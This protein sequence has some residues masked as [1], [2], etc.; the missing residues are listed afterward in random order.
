[1]IRSPA[2]FSLFS[3][4]VFWAGDTTLIAHDGEDDHSHNKPSKVKQAQRY[5]PSVIPDRMILTI[6]GDPRTTQSVTW[7]TSI[8][9]ARGLVEIA[10]ADGSPSF[11]KKAE[12]FV[13]STELLESNLSKANYHS[14]TF[15]KLKPGTVYAYRVGDEG[16]NW[17]EWC[18]F[19]T[20]SDKPEK[21]SFVYFGDA[22]NNVRSMWSRVVREAYRD[23]PRAA[24]FLHA[25][26]LINSAESDGEWGEWFEAGGWLNR[27]TPSI[28]VP[29]N[30][31]Q[32]KA[33]VGT[34]LTK[35]WRP[36][37]TLPENGPKGLE[38]SCYTLV[39]QNLRVIG[40]NSNRM[41][42]EQAKWMDAV[43]QKNTSPWIV[44]S[45][46]HPVFSTGRDRDNAELRKRWKPIFDKYQV[47]L[48]LQGHDHTYGRTGLDVPSIGAFAKY[49]K[50]EKAKAEAAKKAAEAEKA[51]KEGTENG[52]AEKKE[53]EQLGTVVSRLVD[54]IPVAIRAAEAKIESNVP[55]GVQ[56]VDPVS[57][58]VY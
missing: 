22:Q 43:L 53:T 20:A 44:C 38:E 51:A 2:L 19:K 9:V 25:G 57:G 6:S 27:S 45:F 49:M 17:T 35:H 52:G 12:Q 56:K 14:F 21:F 5:K 15:K 42:D 11:T 50:E 47:D 40:L 13:A 16:G 54:A 3:L 41:L 39:Y 23:A 8:D 7:R 28:A 46:H 26:D 33:L 36:S 1:M 55:T 32:A 10:P 30:H 37:F 34:R 29:G 18:Q 4:L 24:F 31:E 58:T 48:V